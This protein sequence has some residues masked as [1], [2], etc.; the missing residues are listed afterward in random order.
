MNQL[1]ANEDI[2]LAALPADV[3]ARTFVVIPAYNEG[4]A[5]AKVV[6]EVRQHFDHVVVVD[7]GSR[8]NTHAVAQDCARYV[9]KHL[10]NRG[11]GAA[12]QTGIEFALIRGADFV[13]TFDADGQH[14]VE[15]I[16]ALLAPILNGDAEIALGSRFLGSATD[17]PA[18]RRLVLKAGVWFTRIFN[19]V[20]LTDAHNGLRA[21]SRKAAQRIHIRQDRMA[22][23]SEIIDL[24]RETELPFVEV[25]VTIRYTEYS[26]AKGQSARGA[27]RIAFHYLV[28]KMVD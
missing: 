14:R 19:G 21:F 16:P 22:H 20:R 6:A 2:S 15:D 24:I 5:L 10:I 3:K 26:L 23:A 13:V 4:P 1:D 28:G 8:D 11:Q 7:D 25:P 18:T 17:L 12:I 9:L 27:L